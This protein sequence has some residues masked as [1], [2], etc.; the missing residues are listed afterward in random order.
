[1][2]DEQVV[3][4]LRERYSDIHPLIFQRSLDKSESAGELF[5]ILDTFPKEFPIEWCRTTK[6]WKISKDVFQRRKLKPEENKNQNNQN[7]KFQ[8]PTGIVQYYKIYY[9]GT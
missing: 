8:I 4:K 9:F 5:D 2:I 3:E 7:N 6:R 1:M